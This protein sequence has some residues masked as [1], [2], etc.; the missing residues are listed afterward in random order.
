[1][2]LELQK[3]NFYMGNS[4]KSDKF[5]H[6]KTQPSDKFQHKKTQSH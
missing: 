5:Q 1:M 6:K 4:P 3:M 2:V